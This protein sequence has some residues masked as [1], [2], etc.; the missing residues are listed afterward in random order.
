MLL[1]LYRL[2][3]LRNS[4][5]VISNRIQTF[6]SAVDTVCA[7]PFNIQ[8][9]STLPYGVYASVPY[10]SRKEEQLLFLEK[11]PQGFLLCDMISEFY[12]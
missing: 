2:I 10:D 12:M 3:P 6:R 7:V 8:K 9:L 5:C 1:F 4:C 11:E